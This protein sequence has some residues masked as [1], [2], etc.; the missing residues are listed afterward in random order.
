VAFSAIDDVGLFRLFIQP[1]S[2][3]GTRRQLAVDSGLE[4]VWSRDGREL[5]FRGAKE[6]LVIPIER[7]KTL[8]W[9]RP[10]HLFDF[11]RATAVRHNFDVAPD[12]RFL[13]V[14]ASPNR[15]P[16]PQLNVVVNWAAE[17][18]SRAPRSR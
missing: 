7:G 18:Q 6:I 15:P 1:A 16:W 14:K 4:P 2:G 3:D 9:G 5:F 10:R 17:L 11:A 13:V 12:G 8:S